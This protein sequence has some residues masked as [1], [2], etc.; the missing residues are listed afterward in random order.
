MVFIRVGLFVIKVKE[1]S[2]SYPPVLAVSDP[3]VWSL[4]SCG[5]PLSLSLPCL[6]CGVK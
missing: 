4:F 6:C 5:I 2:H 1:C 3:A